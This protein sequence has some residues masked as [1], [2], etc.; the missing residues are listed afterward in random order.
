MNWMLDFIR[1]RVAQ[2]FYTAVRL[3]GLF[4]HG[5]AEAQRV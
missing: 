1:H 5:G 4:R 2:V 3:C